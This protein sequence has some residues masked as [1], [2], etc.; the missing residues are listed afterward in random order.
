[1]RRRRD[2]I[3]TPQYYG[4]LR[5]GRL[6]H[7]SATDTPDASALCGARLSRISDDSRWAFFYKLGGRAAQTIG[8]NAKLCRKCQDLAYPVAAT[9]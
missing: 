6:W 5:S 2:P 3:P 4:R 9:G 1:M 7:L 8:M